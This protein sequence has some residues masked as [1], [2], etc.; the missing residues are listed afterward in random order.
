MKYNA[1]H[2]YTTSDREAWKVAGNFFQTMA[3]LNNKDGFHLC[4]WMVLELGLSGGDL[5]A[6]ALVHQFSQSFAGTYTGNTEYLSAWTGWSENTSRKHLSNLVKLGLIK[7][8]RGRKNNSPFCHYQLTDDFYEK[9]PAVFEVS[10]LNNDA[11]HPAEIEDSTPQKFGQEKNNRNRKENNN[12]SPIIPSV[13]QVAEHAKSKG[14]ADPDG[15]AAFY[16]EYNDNRGWIAANGKPIIGWK[17]NINNNWMK[18]KSK[19]F[20]EG[21]KTYQPKFDFSK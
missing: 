19:T 5:I 6:F 8:I 9:H 20:A 12:T 18:F 11:D 7:E 21:N 13:E 15:F 1:C 17:N 3:N 14:F 4:G 10:P 2:K 16:V